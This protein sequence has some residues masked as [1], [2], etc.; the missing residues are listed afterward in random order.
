MCEAVLEMD[1]FCERWRKPVLGRSPDAH[2]GYRRR[3][4][5]NALPRGN[6]CT[7]LKS[8]FSSKNAL[9]KAAAHLSLPERLRSAQS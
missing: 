9:T 8:Q 6:N 4:T 3:A 2:N 5:L 1:S 7:L